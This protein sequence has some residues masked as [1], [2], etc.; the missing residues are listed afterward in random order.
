MTMRVL[1]VGGG[2]RE[3][4]LVWKLGQ[5]PLVGEIICAPGNAGIAELAES[6]QVTPNDLDGIVRLA[7]ERRVDLAVIGPEDPLAAGLAD[8]LTEAGVA[9]AGPSAAAA[10]IESSKAWAKELMHEAGVPTGR[11]IA[12]DSIDAGRRAIAAFVAPVVV[13]ADGLAAGKGVAVCDTI[14]A[15]E[16]TLATYMDQRVFGDAGATVLIEEYLAGQEVS[17]LA[18]TDGHTIYLLAPACD[19]K[20]AFDGDEGPN[21]G[22]MGVYTPVPA[23]DVDLHA[24]IQRT[25]LEPT[26]AALAVNG[27]PMCGVLYA[28][29]ILTADG[30]KVLEFNARFGD[31]E[32]QVVLPTLN[33]DLATLLD[34]VARGRLADVATP[35]A[36]GAAVGVVLASGGYPG[37]YQTGHPI[38]GLDR[39]PNDVLVFHAGTARDNGGRVVTAGGRVLTVVGHGP[40]LASARDRAYAGAAEISFYGMQ[41]R[42]DIALREVQDQGGR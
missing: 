31:P 15:A 9:T 35:R 14:A 20:R 10:R 24:E 4:A 36:D 5:S 29:L 39:V 32:S 18:L 21:T 16:R 6:V 30:P 28:G 25:V 33:G 40:D 17:M 42:Q 12:V 37:A 11:A 13:K 3:H 19:Y 41:M 2:G 1:V 8:R 22:G 34:A 7:K 23:F 27:S 38:D 26:V